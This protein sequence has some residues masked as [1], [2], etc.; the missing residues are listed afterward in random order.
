[1]DNFNNPNDPYGADNQYNPYES[2]SQNDAY[3][4][5]PQEEPIPQ[6]NQIYSSLDSTYNPQDQFDSNQGSS[7]FN[8]YAQADSTS[9]YSYTAPPVNNAY[10]PNPQMNPQYMNNSYVPFNQQAPMPPMNYS[11]PDTDKKNANILCIISLICY[12]LP[13]VLSF[14]Y[15]LVTMNTIDLD[16]YD[17]ESL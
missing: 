10:I 12:F 1:M 11:D 8:G 3:N 5:V 2:N 13:W 14:I 6:D 7:T 17:Y 9:T 4:P 16:S 15:T